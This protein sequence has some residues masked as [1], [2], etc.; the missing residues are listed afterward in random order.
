MTP[1]NER[2]LGFH[3]EK[4]LKHEREIFG[5]QTTTNP[6]FEIHFFS[7]PHTTIASIFTAQ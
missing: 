7:L 6:R 4:N 3:Q 5:N 1:V 2:S